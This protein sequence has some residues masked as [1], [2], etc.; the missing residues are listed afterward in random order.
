MK[1]VTLYDVADHAGVSYQTVSRVVNQAKHVSERTRERVEAAM[2]ELNY[3]PNRM[4]QQLAGKQTPLIGVAT[5]NLALHAP[6]QIV[7]AI[8]SRADRSGASVVIAMVERSGVQACVAAVNNLLGQRVSGLIVNFPLEDDDAATVAAACGGVPVLFLDVSDSSPINSV[9]FSHEAGARLG[10]E[11]LMACGHR[12]I[13]LLAGPQ[14]SVAARQR[15]AGWHRWLAQHQLQPLAQLEGDWSAI[16]GFEQ[17]RSLLN[18][19]TVPQALLVANDQ[20][21]L[22]AMRAISEYGLRVPAD[23]SVIGYDDTEDSSCYIPPLTTVK[24]DFPLLGQSSVDRL[25][26][27]SAGESITGNQLLP[28]TLVERQTVSAPGEQAASPQVLADRLVQIAR[29][30]AQLG[31][32]R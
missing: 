21:A 28:V 1:P 9:S 24:Q 4:A 11:R 32:Q 12:R 14:S 19:G 13:A 18:G 15:L 22:G 25:L 29:Q 6:S 23:I 7:A 10:V 17:T 16:S 20:M 27:M 2:A 30:L 3:I 26:R 5:V 8:K 31:P